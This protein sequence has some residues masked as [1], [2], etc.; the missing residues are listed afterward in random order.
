[1]AFNFLA[2]PPE[3]RVKIYQVLLVNPPGI[4]LEPHWPAVT[5]A[6]DEATRRRALRPYI[7]S[8]RITG[9]SS[10]LHMVDLPILPVV[11]CYNSEY[12][13][14]AILRA[15]KQI[16]RESVHV[17]Y[18]DN[19][20]SVDELFPAGELTTQMYELG[21]DIQDL[22]L[23]LLPP[24]S[25]ISCGV[26]PVLLGF[27]RGI[28]RTNAQFVRCISMP[29]PLLPIRLSPAFLGG[30]E[31]G[32]C[33]F[34]EEL[35]YY[36]NPAQE[37]AARQLGYQNDYMRMVSVLA[38]NL[39]WLE[40]TISDPFSAFFYDPVHLEALTAM[41]QLI[42]SLRNTSFLIYKQAGSRTHDRVIRDF[43]ERGWPVD[44]GC[45]LCRCGQHDPT[46]NSVQPE[47]EDLVGCDDFCFHFVDEEEEK[48]KKKKKRRSR[49]FGK[50]RRRKRTARQG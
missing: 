10:S 12:W 19:S 38:P 27:L 39:D 46:K 45:V 6:E 50:V 13:C 7:P 36:R 41:L 32:L 37:R 2:L 34:L 11:G 21:E 24:A 47:D 14:P 22:D 20:F 1:M 31:P 28:G 43:T 33:N 23:P 49:T 18:W 30:L 42:P 16:Y 40:L 17:L 8:Q 44:F 15:N 5:P 29:A 26:V 4:Y 3:I 48:K 25:I 9:T 35:L